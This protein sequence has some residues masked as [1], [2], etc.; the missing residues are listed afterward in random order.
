LET[1]TFI[2]SQ[3]GANISK[4]ID[5][6]ELSVK[7][8]KGLS[9]KINKLASASDDETIYF[10]AGCFKCIGEW[11]TCNEAHSLFTTDYSVGQ[12]VMVAIK[13]GLESQHFQLQV[14]NN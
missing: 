2:A 7:L 1:F 12:A 5:T 3:S 13:T 14:R 4:Y 10:I 11:V 8:I 6:S 9:S